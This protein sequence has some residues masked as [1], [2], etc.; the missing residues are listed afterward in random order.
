MPI[1]DVG[2]V[3]SKYVVSGTDFEAPKRYTVM[4]P[5][6]Q[7][8]YGIVCSAKDEELGETIAI[9]KIENVFEHLTFA[10][11]TLRELRILRHLQHENLLAVNGVYFSGTVDDFQDI[12]VA[13]ELMEADLASVLKSNQPISDEH[14]QFFLYQVFRGLKYIHSADVVHRD[15]KPRNLLVNGNCDLKICDYGLARVNFDEANIPMTEYV[16]TRWY[17]A[18]EVLCSWMDY[19]KAIDIWSAG[20][21]LAEMIRRKPLFPGKNTQHQ[22]HLIITTLGHPSANVIQRI[23]NVKCQRFIEG[24][25]HARG[26]PFQEVVPEASQDAI[27][28]L[29]STICFSPDQRVNVDQ[30]LELSYLSELHCPD[31]EPIRCPLETGEFEFERRKI[32]MSVLRQ[33]I[34]LEALTYNP[35]RKASYCEQQLS[36]GKAFEIQKYRLLEPGESQYTSDDEEES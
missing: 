30:A 6:G 33:E 17:R 18:P 1:N 5:I 15:L 28:V 4:E 19:G 8:A 12:Y 27:Q 7:G 3:M 16:C 22:L 32:D 35:E 31:D 13:S 21:I 36:L 9:K 20:C 24:M 2:L 11:R 14:C 29:Q 34:F 23:P 26:E 25:P 10:K